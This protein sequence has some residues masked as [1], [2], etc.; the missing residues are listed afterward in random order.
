MCGFAGLLDTAPHREGELDDLATS[1]ATTLRHRGPDDGGTWS[2][3][4]AGVALGSR[5]L[6]VIDLSASGHQP[7]VSSTGRYVIAYNGEIYNH[8]AIARRLRAT[9]WQPRGHSDTEV[10]LAAVEA[11]GLRA[12]LRE[13]NGMF[14]FALWD[15]DRRRL[16]LARDRLGEKPLYYAW[17]GSALVFG[18]ELKALRAW[19]GFRAEVDRGALALYLRHN[20][21]PAP[22]TIFE[23]VSKLPPAAVLSVGAAEMARRGAEPAA[24]WSARAVAEGGV[25]VTATAS[26]SPPEVVD[27]VEGLLKEAVGM[28]MDADVALGAFLSGGIDS[29]TVAALMQASSSRP[30]RTFTVGFAEAGYDESADAAAV[31]RHLGTDHTPVRLGPSDAIDV[32]P[33]LPAIYDEPFADSSAI[34]TYL[35]SRLARERVTVT[36]SGDG[37]DELWGGYNRHT[38]SGPL[39]SLSR[40]VPLSARRSLARA[41]RAIPPASWDTA[42]DRAGPWLPRRARLRNPGTKIHKLAAVLPASDPEDL[43]RTL[44]SHWK[45][46]ARVALGAVEAPSLLAAGMPAGV[47]GDL[48][49]QMMYL[50]LV[51]YLPDDI[52]VK[53]DRAAMAVSLETRVPMLDHRL[54]E[55]AWR[56]PTSTK[57]VGGVGK[58]PLRQVLRRYVPAGLVERPKMGFGLPLG[59]WLREPLRPWAEELL[60]ERRLRAEGYLEA[61]IVRSAWADHLDGGVDLGHELWDVLSFQ[62][63]LEEWRGH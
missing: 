17:L 24:Y 61:D 1:M 35:V 28:R 45:Q 38:V 62:A 34:P 41:L 26:P 5:R 32:I 15:R 49:A 60:G 27:E 40:R 2:D 23:G 50:D 9:G 4:S 10:L 46:P 39:W 12:A 36:L 19:P 16:Y 48:A 47:G 43:Y 20:C 59:D 3:A 63:W 21:V 33:S 51:T 56:V 29:S 37:G 31:A 22:H 6:A 25:A 54:V 55:L 57:I 18:S 7:M 58:W 14:A 52:L 53:L 42:F 30:I 11:W 44:V 13:A 8:K